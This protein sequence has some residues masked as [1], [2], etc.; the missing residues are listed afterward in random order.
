M[1]ESVRWGLLL[2]LLVPPFTVHAQTLSTIP[3]P[4][5]QSVWERTAQ[6][7]GAQYLSYRQADQPE[8]ATVEGQSGEAEPLPEPMAPPPPSNNGSAAANGHAGPL[9]DY[10]QAASPS[11]VG[12]YT[13]GAFCN[14]CAQGGHGGGWLH[15]LFS[16]HHGDCGACG[17]EV[18]SDTACADATCTDATCA[19]AAC[20][21]CGCGNWFGGVY[22]LVLTRADDARVPLSYD[23]ANWGHPLLRSSDADTGYQGGAG[24]RFGR[25]FNCNTWGV[26]AGYWGLV[27]NEAEANV[28][29]ACLNVDLTSPIRFDNLVYDNGAFT[30][31]VLLWYGTPSN[32][33][34][35][36]RLRRKFEAH[37]IELNLIR[38]PYRR[39]GCVHFELLAGI[40]YLKFDDN[41]SLATDFTSDAFGDDPANELDYVIDVENNLLGFQVGG[42]MDYYVW[43]ALSVNAGTTFGIYGNH[44]RHQQ[45]IWGGNGFATVDG[46]GDVYNVER[47]A[48]DVAFLGDLFAGVSYDISA[49][50][51]ITCGYRAMVASGVALATSQIPRETEFANMVYA[52]TL[53]SNDSLVLHG[54][55][56]GLE[57]NW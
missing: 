1:K 14:K 5:G 30:D 26:E 42:R 44:M 38:N 45:F 32:P 7:P 41:F 10:S 52:P 31:D 46:T 11:P 12:A 27:P 3:W 13:T 57:F 21:T 2:T 53:D 50:W 56:A 24:V 9:Y 43:G 35:R 51:R 55:Y 29:N 36:H 6:A 18:C 39:N 15:G 33:A 20:G 54:G 47:T 37:N 23:G 17:G 49:C 48:D 16:A 28:C 4:N 40:R 25:Y 34:Q 8:A 19:E 22:G